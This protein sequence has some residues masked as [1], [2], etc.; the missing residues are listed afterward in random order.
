MPATTASTAIRWSPRSTPPPTRAGSAAS[1]CV[2]CVSRAGASCSIHRAGSLPASCSTRSS[3]GS[4]LPNLHLRRRAHEVTL[5]ELE[6][7]MPQYVVG[8]AAVE[9]EIRQRIAE[10]QR[11]AGE[12]AGGAAR[13]G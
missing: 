4:A 13:E 7:A 11:L 12:L 1:S 6:P 9:I 8:G 3:P 5:A 2:T 10:Q